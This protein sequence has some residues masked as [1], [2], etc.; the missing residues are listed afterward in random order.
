MPVQPEK[1][2]IAE[3]R[4]RRFSEAW[5]EFR[6]EVDLAELK[7]D[8]DEVFG[9]VRDIVDVAGEPSSVVIPRRAD[10]AESPG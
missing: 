5:R 2:A 3:A 7:I 8:P 1:P 10:D 4:T 6:R 9:N